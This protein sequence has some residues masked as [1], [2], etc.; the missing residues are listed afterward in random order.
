MVRNASLMVLML[1]SAGKLMFNE[2]LVDVHQRWSKLF[3]PPMIDSGS[4]LI[5]IDEGHEP[6][7]TALLIP[8]EPDMLR[9][10]HRSIATFI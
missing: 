2:W 9:H 5:W 1:V 7:I 10:V 4:S 8:F 6:P 3:C